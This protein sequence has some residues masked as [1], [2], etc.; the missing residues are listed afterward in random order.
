MFKKNRIKL[1]IQTTNEHIKPGY[2]N[3]NP[4]TKL[5]HIQSSPGF[6]INNRCNGHDILWPLQISVELRISKTQ[7][8]NTSV[9]LMVLLVIISHSNLVDV[10]R[11]LGKELL[12]FQPWFLLGER[13]SKNVNRMLAFRIVYIKQIS[14]LFQNFFFVIF[15][16]LSFD[17]EL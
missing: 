9:A 17:S 1:I 12:L 5:I 16:F 4:R 3:V 6:H 13:L 15:R 2:D 7:L 11:K 8:L 10:S 14:L